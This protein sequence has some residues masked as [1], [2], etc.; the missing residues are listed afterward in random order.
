[1]RYLTRTLPLLLTLMMLIGSAAHGYD[2]NNNSCWPWTGNQGFLYH[3]LVTPNQEEYWLDPSD[4]SWKYVDSSGTYQVPIGGHT[5]SVQMWIV[6]VYAFNGDLMY[7]CD[8]G[9][10]GRY[11]AGAKCVSASSGSFSNWDSC[12]DYPYYQDPGKIFLLSRPDSGVLYVS[13]PNNATLWK[14]VAYYL[15]GFNPNHRVDLQDQKANPWMPYDT[16]QWVGQY[17]GYAKDYNNKTPNCQ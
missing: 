12:G 7:G 16:D 3:S 5:Y 14:N 10:P 17:V 8:G 6:G 4:N 2:D 13:T 15:C 11:I 9:T 1:M